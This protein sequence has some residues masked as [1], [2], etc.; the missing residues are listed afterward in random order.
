VL[1]RTIAVPGLAG[2]DTFTITEAIAGHHLGP[3]S[4]RLLATP[5]TGGRAGNQQQATFQITP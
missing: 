5:T 3:G 2:A 1:L 4:Y